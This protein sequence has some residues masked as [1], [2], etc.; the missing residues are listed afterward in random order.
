MLAMAEH[1]NEILYLLSGIAML[2]VGLVAWFG[3]KQV[4]RLDCVEKAQK[5]IK[6]NY[7]DRFDKV[8]DKLDSIHT[9]VT[10]LHTEHKIIIKKHLD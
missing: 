7:L 5:E 10:E 3:K 6:D 2:F 1:I 8:N 9:L 4:E